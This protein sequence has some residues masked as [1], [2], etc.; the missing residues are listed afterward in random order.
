MLLRKIVILIIL[1]L[2]VTLTACGGV[3]HKAA[4]T[5]VIAHTHRMS[6]PAGYVVTIR[7]EDTTKAGSPGKKF[8]EVVIKSQGEMLPF[9]FAIVYDPA[10]INPDHTYSV[11]AEIKDPDGILLY[12][13]TTSVPVITQG[14]PIRDVKVTVVLPDQ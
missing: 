3:S 2:S 13:S 6:L 1:S 10:R 7:I 5:G 14:N 11:R 4:I 9:P 8:A 12:T